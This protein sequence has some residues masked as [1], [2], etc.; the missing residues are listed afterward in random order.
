MPNPETTKGR[1]RK[2]WRGR[3][4]GYDETAIVFAPTAGR[5]RMD[6]WRSLDATVRIIDIS[7]RREPKRDVILPDRD[8][9]A[10]TLSD[11]ERN[12][13]LH[14]FGADT[15]DPTKA[16]YR[17]YFYTRRDDPPLVALTE[18]GLMSPM[19]GDKWGENMTYFVLTE[20]GKRVA[21]SMVPEYAR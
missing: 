15:T 14:A 3:A 5:A 10:D 21:L 9:I 2:A 19:A 18:R 16:G 11:A 20:A 6:V 13:L 1:L 7:V 8:P 12:C 4:R 17:D